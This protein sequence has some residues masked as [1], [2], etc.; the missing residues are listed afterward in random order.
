MKRGPAKLQYLSKGGKCA[1]VV[2]IGTPTP[3]M[4]GF[5]SS[6]YIGYSSIEHF[7]EHFC[8]Y[9][10]TGSGAQPSCTRVAQKPRIRR[11][12]SKTKFVGRR[13]GNLCRI[14]GRQDPVENRVLGWSG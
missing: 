3:A 14:K 6:E 7:T 9:S 10:G 13:E 1:Y 4:S 12:R 8:I 11:G 2:F 5:P